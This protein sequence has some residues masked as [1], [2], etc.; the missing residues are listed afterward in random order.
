MVDE[1]VRSDF[2]EQAVNKSKE[3]LQQVRRLFDLGL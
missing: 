3:I 2:P 1:G